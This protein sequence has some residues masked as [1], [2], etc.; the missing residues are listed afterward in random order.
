MGERTA[1]AVG[2]RLDGFAVAAEQVVADAEPGVHRRAAVR[3]V[4]ELADRIAQ[5]AVAAVVVGD[6]AGDLLDFARPEGRGGDDRS[7]SGPVSTPILIRWEL[8]G[9][10]L[11]AV[12]PLAMSQIARHS[13]ADG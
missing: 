13:T 9:G 6:R 5:V 4:F 12:E 3:L 7:A 1:V 2:E 10:K 8:R 11:L